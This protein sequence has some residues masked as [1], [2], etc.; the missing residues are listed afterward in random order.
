MIKSK[1]NLNLGICR[2]LNYFQLKSNEM[3]IYNLLVK[4]PM[5]IKQIQKI[6]KMSERSLRTHLDDLVEKN[7]VQRKLTESKHLKYVYYTN[8]GENILNI[9]KRR[10]DDLEKKRQKRRDDIVSGTEEFIK[11]GKK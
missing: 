10:I 4:K 7:F 8:S 1:D 9:L 5:T 3:I 2:F 6:T 11:I